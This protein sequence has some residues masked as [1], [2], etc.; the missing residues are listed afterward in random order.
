MS[1]VI[2]DLEKIRDELEELECIFLRLLERPNLRK[3]HLMALDFTALS[4]AVDLAV[5]NAQALTDVP[6]D[7]TSQTMID[8][9]TAKLEAANAQ[10]TALLPPA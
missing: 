1:Q 6:K 10:T 9:L 3:V 7:T 4:T 5:T 8:E 2:R